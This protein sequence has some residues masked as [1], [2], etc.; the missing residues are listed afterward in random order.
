MFYEAKA[1]TIRHLKVFDRMFCYKQGQAE[2]FLNK[3]F[4]CVPLSTFTF[5]LKQNN[6]K[7]YFNN[8]DGVKDQVQKMSA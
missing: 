4:C 2:E 1:L 7:E 6:W 3:D 8:L 5:V